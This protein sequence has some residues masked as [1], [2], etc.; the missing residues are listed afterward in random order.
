MFR[1]EFALKEF[2]LYLE[3]G[4]KDGIHQDEEEQGGQSM[5]LKTVP[6]LA[7]MLAQCDMPHPPARD[8]ISQTLVRYARG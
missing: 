1:K 6:S 5:L 7:N 3:Q 4:N 2:Y 8:L